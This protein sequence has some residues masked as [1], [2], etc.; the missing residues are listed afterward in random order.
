M[1]ELAADVAVAT[2]G[3]GVTCR[4]CMDRVILPTSALEIWAKAH[5][6]PRVEWMDMR[7]GDGPVQR[8]APAPKGKKPPHVT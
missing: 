5:R 8:W 2:L 4:A 3:Y 1:A 6:D 7:I